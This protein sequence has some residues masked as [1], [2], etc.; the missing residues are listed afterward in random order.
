MR[1]KHKRELIGL[2][3]HPMPFLLKQTIPMN[4][5][6]VHHIP[7]PR[8]SMDSFNDKKETPVNKAAV[9]QMVATQ[10]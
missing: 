5:Y 8:Y 10:G 6:R 3:Q 4:N 7:S 2:V 9:I 1:K